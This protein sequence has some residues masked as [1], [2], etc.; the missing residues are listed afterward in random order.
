MA[1]AGNNKNS[2]RDETMRASLFL[3]VALAMAPAAAGDLGLFEDQSDVG[4]VRPPGSATFDKA[5]Q[6]YMLTAAGANVWGQEDAFHF[7]WKKSER[8][9]F[10][11]RRC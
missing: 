11:D 9:F 5:K 4:T 3:A 6:I 8:R 2:N 1:Y 10:P 7:V